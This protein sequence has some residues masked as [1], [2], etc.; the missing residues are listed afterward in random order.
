MAL[1]NSRRITFEVDTPLK[2][3]A[4]FGLLADVR[5]IP[6][7][8]Y[9]QLYLWLGEVDGIDATGVAVLVRIHGHLLTRSKRLAL[10]GV[11]ESVR[12]NLERVG[13]LSVIPLAPEENARTR[14]VLQ[15]GRNPPPPA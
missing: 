5:R 2:G 10:V 15:W 7:D 1:V 14:S 9:D 4:A 8:R 6:P 13:L 3:Q 12:A 11:Q